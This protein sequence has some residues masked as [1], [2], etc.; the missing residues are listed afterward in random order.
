[1][2]SVR[3]FAKQVPPWG[4]ILAGSQVVDTPKINLGASTGQTSGCAHQQCWHY[5]WPKEGDSRG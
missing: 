4:N 5:V 2:E 1:M 3:G